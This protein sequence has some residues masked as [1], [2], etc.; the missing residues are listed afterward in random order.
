MLAPTGVSP[1]RQAK[2]ENLFLLTMGAMLESS[3]K[4]VMAPGKKSILSA[5]SGFLGNQK[6]I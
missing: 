2:C 4:R 5:L 6:L 1:I 3:E